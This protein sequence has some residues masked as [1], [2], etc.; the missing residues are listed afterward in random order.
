MF[1]LRT[2]LKKYL[3]SISLKKKL[4]LLFVFCVL[5]PLIITNGVVF[6]NLYRVNKITKEQELRSD[7]EAIKY[8]FIDGLDYPAKIIQNVYKNDEI[9][10]L[11]NREY[12]TPLDYYSAYM[13]FKKESIY[14][15]LLGIGNET[16]Q[17][18]ADNDTI[19]NGGMFYKLEPVKNEAWYKKVSE[20]DGVVL[21]FE[22]NKEYSDA[23]SKRDVVLMRKMDMARRSRVEKIV[24]MTINY[25]T[26]QDSIL[27]EGIESDAYICLGDK[28]LMT[29]VGGT[30][31]KE[32]YK[33]IDKNLKYDYKYDI[34]L[35]G[36][37][38]TIYLRNR[39]MGIWVLDLKS[40]IIVFCLLALSIL[41]PIYMIRQL[42]YSV[43]QRIGVL[44]KIFEKTDD[45]QLTKISHIEGDDEIASL[46]K[47]Y[48]KMSDRM[49]QLI[50]T[51]YVDKLKQQEMDIARQNAELLALHSQINPHFLFNALE[52]I[53]MHS[54]LK[55]EKETSEM[56]EHLAVMQRV[57]VDWH[58]DSVSVEEELKFIQAYL[59]LQKYRFGERLNYN[60]DVSPDC[61]KAMLPKLSIVTFV[62]NACVHGI[63]S[64]T[65]PGWIFVRIYKTDTEMVFEIEDTGIG[66]DEE[67]R[68]NLLFK[69]NNASL[70]LIKTG[71]GV[72]MT[73]ACL[74]LK[75]MTDNKARFDLETEQG[76]GTT[77]LIT[78]PL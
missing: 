16:L 30:H 40:T 20:S 35:Y 76:V 61:Y 74:R 45:E 26:F 11:L 2:R 54:L 42:D 41:L 71:R 34:Y 17:I 72:G 57:N 46:M 39:G 8:S 75:M 64:K 66:M 21:N 4:M 60:L 7:A 67:M 65:E 18:Y 51:A 31:Y 49:N 59:E 5:I 56:V 43:A 36:E 27:N 68:E 78:I 10:D 48:N 15:S 33:F 9:E 3:I 23:S 70:E 22:F 62:E 55:N 29:N 73:N 53:R 1:I 77:V 6:Y 44:S 13:G 63:E 12:Y 24:R 58:S 37:T 28:L 19:L 69:M 14:D 47:N 25:R 52:S 38:Y 32:S 50:Q